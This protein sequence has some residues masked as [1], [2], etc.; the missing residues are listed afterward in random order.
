M[1]FKYLMNIPFILAIIL[2]VLFMIIS[3]T[4]ATD[5]NAGVQKVK[6]FQQLLFSNM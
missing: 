5:L 3:S 6:F 2:T 1:T 4:S